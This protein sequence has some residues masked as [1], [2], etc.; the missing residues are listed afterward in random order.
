M[1]TARY[2]LGLA[3]LDGK[4]YAAGGNH[5]DAAANDY[6]STVEVFDPSSNQWRPAPSM[7]TARNAPGLAALDGKLFAAGGQ[8]IPHSGF[9]SSVEVFDPSTNQWQP[10]PSMSTA[11]GNLGLAALDGK[12]YAAG[13]Q[14]PGQGGIH[15]VERFWNASA[16]LPAAGAGEFVEYAGAKTATRA[17]RGHGGTEIDD[18]PTTVALA[19]C[20]ASCR[21]TAAC[22]CFTYDAA[23]SQC[24]RRTACKPDYFEQVGFVKLCLR[25]RA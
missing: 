21:A 10:A 22:E 6:L 19:A 11:R 14:L 9:L 5:G 13:G 15:T 4:L 7:S 20:A 2:S 1:S 8:K 17:T 12:L 25:V 18:T 24:W 3:A 23:A 16:A